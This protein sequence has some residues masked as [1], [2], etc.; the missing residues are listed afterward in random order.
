MNVVLPLHILLSM[1]LL[2]IISNMWKINEYISF[3]YLENSNFSVINIIGHF[4]IHEV[5]LF[6]TD[7]FSNNSAIV[8]KSLL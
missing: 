8:H 7:Y 5:Y 3:F 1:N 4:F 2:F 6:E